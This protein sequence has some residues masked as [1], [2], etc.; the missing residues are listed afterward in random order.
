[1]PHYLYR[2]LGSIKPEAPIY[3]AKLKTYDA[4]RG[5]D[6]RPETAQALKRCQ[7]FLLF[8]PLGSAEISATKSA[9]KQSNTEGNQQGVYQT[10]FNPLIPSTKDR[11]ILA[12][13]CFPSIAG[14]IGML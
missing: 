7:N 3:H 11:I 5:S 4:R 9:L 10:L 6:L 2:Q 12:E 14:V 8:E 1:M 13:A